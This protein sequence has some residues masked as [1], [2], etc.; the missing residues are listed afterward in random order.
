MGFVRYGDDPEGPTFMATQEE[1]EF[2]LAYFDAI[3]ECQY[4]EAKLRDCLKLVI[5]INELQPVPVKISLDKVDKLPLGKLVMLLKFEQKASLDADLQKIIPARNRLAHVFLDNTIGERTDTAWL[6]ERVREMKEIQKF[7]QRVR[8]EV[9]DEKNK[10]LR[11]S[12]FPKRA[13]AK[14]QK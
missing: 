14:S 4:L 9:L 7:V 8:E 2:K 3:Q 11:L 5:Q 12:L 10:L 6:T 1:T 13:E